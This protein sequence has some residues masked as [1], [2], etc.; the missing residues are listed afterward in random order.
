MNGEL[1]ASVLIPTTGDRGDLLRY[2]VGS[3]LRQ[4]ENRLE[5]LVIGDG[6]SSNSRG[7]VEEMARSDNRIRIF[8]FPKH[9]NRG[10]PNRHQILLHEAR[11]R[12]IFYLC[13][14]NLLLPDHVERLGRLLKDADVAHGLMVA[15]RPDGQLVITDYSRIFGF[16]VVLDLTRESQRRLTVKRGSVLPL[17]SW[18]HTL[19]FYRKLPRGWET[20]PAGWYSDQ[21]ML[22]QLLAHPGC[23]VATTMVPTALNFQRLWRGQDA[24]SVWRHELPLWFEKLNEPHFA[25]QLREDAMEKAIVEQQTQIVEQQTEIDQLATTIRFFHRHPL[26][27]VSGKLKSRIKARLKFRL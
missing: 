16:G 1:E 14:R 27:Y 3:V 22:A 25:E 20:P 17:S 15:I 18:G 26:R 5:I 23:K 8:G 24:V 7:A 9:E 19:G 21:H 12:N 4:T 2:S 11:G 10:E 6:M 13:D